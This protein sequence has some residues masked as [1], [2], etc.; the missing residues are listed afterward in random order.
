[1]LVETILGAMTEPKA[2]GPK[3]LRATL[4]KLDMTQMELARRLGVDG[5]TVR[6][7]LAGAAPIPG[8]VRAALQCMAQ[9]DDL[10]RLLAHE[11]G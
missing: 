2:M 7:W 10:R 8:P 1:M 4:R 9:L 6:R 5:R 11:E 3:Q